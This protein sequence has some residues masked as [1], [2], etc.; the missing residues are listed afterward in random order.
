LL[1]LAIQPYEEAV[2][3]DSASGAEEDDATPDV[4][5]EDPA[6]DDAGAEAEAEADGAEDTLGSPSFG[7]DVLEGDMW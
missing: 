4:A 3:S 1:T 2:S 7:H 5:I 6:S